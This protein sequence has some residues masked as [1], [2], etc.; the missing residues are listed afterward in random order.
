MWLQV[1]SGLTVYRYLDRPELDRVLTLSSDWGT[2]SSSGA[3]SRA[4]VCVAQAAQ[5]TGGQA[6][7]RDTTC[8][9]EPSTYH[10]LRH[11]Q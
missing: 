8:H 2:S 6:T 3:S 1:M 7:S 4:C 9:C 5:V 10:I 11:L